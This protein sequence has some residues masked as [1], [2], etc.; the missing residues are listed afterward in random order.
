ME[1]KLCQTELE[2]VFSKL[3]KDWLEQHKVVSQ[4]FYDCSGVA[5]PGNNAL[6]KILLFCESF[7]L[8]RTWW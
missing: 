8:K 3:I 6:R 4:S 7:R 5:F 1:H 2:E